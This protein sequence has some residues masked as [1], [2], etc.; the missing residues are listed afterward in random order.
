MH[1]NNTF[2]RLKKYFTNIYTGAREEII[3][4]SDTWRKRK[5]KKKKIDEKSGARKKLYQPDNNSNDL[6]YISVLPRLAILFCPPFSRKPRYPVEGNNDIHE[7]DRARS[8][9]ASSRR[10]FV[11]RR[12]ARGKYV[13]GTLAESRA[14]ANAFNNS[15]SWFL[16]PRIAS[17][18]LVTHPPTFRER[19]YRFGVSYSRYL[20]SWN[21]FQ[22]MPSP[23]R[24]QQ[25]HTGN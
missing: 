2:S 4:I 6:V 21:T 14:A 19:W 23:K 22:W 13:R 12:R 8:D 5:K 25:Q 7:H 10:N 9:S 3:V 24:L 17:I 1:R 18:D 20:I 16:P 15:Q 11:A